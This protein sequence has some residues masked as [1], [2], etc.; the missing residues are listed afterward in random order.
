MGH[1]IKPRIY[2]ALLRVAATIHPDWENRGDFPRWRGVGQ[3]PG[4]R[5]LVRWLERVHPAIAKA[6]T[7]A[8]VDGCGP[9]AR[10]RPPA[11]RPGH[12]GPTIEG[13][14]HGDTRSRGA[15]PR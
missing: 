8:I 1:E 7:M 2:G 3:C 5:D 6:V 4:E 15:E 11:H 12:G 14:I 13:G 9:R 10:Y